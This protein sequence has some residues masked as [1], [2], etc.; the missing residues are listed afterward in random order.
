MRE[1][2]KDVDMSHSLPS[3]KHMPKQPVGNHSVKKPPQPTEASTDVDMVSDSLVPEKDEPQWPITTNLVEE[4]SQLKEAP[5]DVVMASDSLP[6]EKNEP[7]LP[8]NIKSSGRQ[9][10]K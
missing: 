8:V 2:P 9:R 7:S 4:P 6:S 1:A 5:N 3:E 10:S